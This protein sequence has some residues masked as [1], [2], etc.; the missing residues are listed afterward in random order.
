MIFQKGFKLGFYYIIML[1]LSEIK[2]MRK[3]L[4]LTQKQLAEKARVSQSLIAKIESGKIDPTYHN[5]QKISSALDE[6]T[7]HEGK[8]AADIMNKHVISLKPRDKAKG[9]VMIMKK[10]AISQVPIILNNK[11]MGIVSESTILNHL[12]N[13]LD[14][15]SLK[16]ILEDAPPIIPKETG[17]SVISDMLKHFPL[18]IVQDSGK[19]KG[20]ITKADLFKNIKRIF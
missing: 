12:E 7:R 14:S 19:L 2:Q 17:I 3:N 8:K 10:Y 11:L 16:D 9:A 5:V 18:L 1:A 20:V 4:G 13:N 15:L 6:L